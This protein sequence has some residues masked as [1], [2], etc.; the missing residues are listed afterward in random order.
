[1]LNGACFAGA[2]TLQ[3]LSGLVVGLAEDQGAEIA[4]R[5]LFGFLAVALVLAILS[6]ARSPDPR[7]LASAA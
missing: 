4:Y 3:A 1:L 6:Y 7:R 5:A 2:A